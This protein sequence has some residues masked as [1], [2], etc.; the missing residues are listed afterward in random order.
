MIALKRDRTDTV[1]KNKYKGIEKLAWDKKLLLAKRS[2]LKEEI[3]KIEFESNYWTDAKKQLKKESFGKCAYC[4]APTNAVAHGD[5]EHFRPKS[6]YWWLAYTYDNYLYSC[7]ICNQLYKSDNFPILSKILPEPKLTATTSD[8]DIDALCGFLS[9]DPVD[10]LNRYTLDKFLKALKKEKATL[11]NPY[12][13]NPDTVLAWESDDNLEE[14]KLI[15]SKAQYS[16]IIKDMEA[17]YG[18]NRV[19]LRSL[20][21]QSFSLF[22]VFKLTL[23]DAG[24]SANTKAQTQKV[25]DNMKSDKYPF[26]GMIRYFD[27]KL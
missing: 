23:N 24:V 3:S 25:I 2:L 19:E 20:R 13:D 16:Q 5:V 21:Y 8:A 17:Y 7:Q 18:I 9:P 1:I 4:E 12:F 15:P 11:L 14:V 6:K 22:R 27:K 26:A 10:I